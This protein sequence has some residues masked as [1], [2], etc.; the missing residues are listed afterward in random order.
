MLLEPGI[1]RGTLRSSGG[2]AV[3]RFHY[4]RVHAFSVRSSLSTIRSRD[5][6]SSTAWRALIPPMPR[7]TTGEYCSLSRRTRAR[8][9]WRGLT[10][11][12]NHQEATC[13]E[14]DGRH[15]HKVDDLVHMAI[16]GSCFAEEP[17]AFATCS[18][19]GDRLLR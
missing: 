11:S 5:Y 10:W 9:S 13:L 15:M 2:S 17:G 19:S 14:A 8:S 7:A 6:Q 18:G 4:W 1:L 12:R 16:S 3:G